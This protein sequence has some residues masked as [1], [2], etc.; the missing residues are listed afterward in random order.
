MLNL[1]S[2]N[3]FPLIT[4]CQLKTMSPPPFSIQA[5][6]VYL[7]SIIH[8]ETKAKECG[9]L[10]VQITSLLKTEVLLVMT[11]KV[12][13][14]PLIT[15]VELY[16][17]RKCKYQNHVAFDSIGKVCRLEIRELRTKCHEPLGGSAPK[18]KTVNTFWNDNNILTC[19]NLNTSYK[20]NTNLNT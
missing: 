1:V 10:K 8:F 9:S 15:I 17:S 12:K 4:A 14:K 2:R 18:T 3:T 5:V 7:W 20:F 16:S 11:R 19:C 6:T 13:K